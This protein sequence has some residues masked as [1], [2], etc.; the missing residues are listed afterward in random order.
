MNHKKRAE[1][2]I[3]YLSH[4]KD[5]EGYAVVDVNLSDGSTLYNPLST[6]DNRDLSDDIYD[7]IESQTNV[8]PSEV[9]L[10]VRFHGDVEEKEREEIKQAMKRH[11]TFKSL[12]VSWDLAANFRKAL[13]L[14]IFGVVVLALYFYLSFTSNDF[15]FAEILSI[16]G[17]FSLWEAADALFLE[18]PSL[19]RE[20]KNIEQSLN[21]LVEFL[22]LS[23]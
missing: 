10:R 23:E 17:S 13:L 15:F 8:I 1:E 16:V 20:V 9:P 3:K 6:R 2:L 19:K 4:I 21:Q 7:Y 12:D 5:E 22:P 11:Y 14:I 18:R